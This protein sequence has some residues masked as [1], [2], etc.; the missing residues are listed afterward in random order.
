MKVKVCCKNLKRCDGKSAVKALKCD[1]PDIKFKK[2]DC[3]GRCGACKKGAIAQIGK[4]SF[5]C[6]SDPDT[7]Y[8]ELKK[9]LSLTG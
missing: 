6:K 8:A 4:G 9:L 1:F 3:L 5:L 2:K 7:L